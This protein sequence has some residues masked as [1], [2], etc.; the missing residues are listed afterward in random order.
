MAT[1]YDSKME[2]YDQKISY[3]TDEVTKKHLKLK[4]MIVEKLNCL[5]QN[6]MATEGNTT[7]LLNSDLI[8]KHYK[9]KI[10]REDWKAY[11]K[12]TLTMRSDKT[13]ENCVE[14]KFYNDGINIITTWNDVLCVDRGDLKNTNLINESDIAILTKMR[15]LIQGDDYFPY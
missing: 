14:C 7:K 3:L 1:D 10:G 2:E 12:I 8:V 4:R 13:K 5:F 9:Y 15:Y 6:L 11:Q